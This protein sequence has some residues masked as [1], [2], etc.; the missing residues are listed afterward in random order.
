MIFTP[1]KNLAILK[2]TQHLIVEPKEAVSFLN[3]GWLTVYIDWGTGPVGSI[4]RAVIERN[5]FFW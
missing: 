2:W 4:Y 5:G 3:T 1:S